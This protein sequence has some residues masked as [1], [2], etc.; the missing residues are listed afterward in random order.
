MVI[1]CRCQYW[2]VGRGR[3]THGN[4][5][6]NS[7]AAVVMS[8]VAPVR[9]SAYHEGSIA[10]LCWTMTVCEYLT[11]CCTSWS[12]PGASASYAVETRTPGTATRV[13]S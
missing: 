4:R 7:A 9:A 12:T 1:G 13:S 3:C 5:G 6:V 11:W 10:S 8:G 2:C